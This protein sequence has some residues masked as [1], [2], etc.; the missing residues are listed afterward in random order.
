MYCVFQV[1]VCDIITANLQRVSSVS[2]SGHWAIWHT[3]ANQTALVDGEGALCNS[4][5]KEFLN[6]VVHVSDPQLG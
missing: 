1:T 3:G 4:L 5:I 2:V 6:N